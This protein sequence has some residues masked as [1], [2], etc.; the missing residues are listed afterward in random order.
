M[1]KLPAGRKPVGSKWV[2][3]VKYNNDGIINKFKEKVVTQGYLQVYGIDFE[4]TYASTVRYDMLRLLFA[5]AAIEDW[6]I[7]QI[8][9]ISTYLAGELKEDIYMHPP[10]GY[11]VP[12]RE[13]C[14]LL[15]SIYSLKQAA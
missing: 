2:F 10:E 12:E 4:K 15:K 5:I 6:E 13:F 11:D 7:H 8:D 3:K 14:H 9:A 1:A